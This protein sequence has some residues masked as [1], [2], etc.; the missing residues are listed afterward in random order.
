[1]RITSKGQVTIPIEIRESA[2]LLPGTDVA[3]RMQDGVVVVERTAST[4]TAPSR[5]DLAVRALYGKGMRGVTTDE[6]MTLL[7][8][9]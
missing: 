6:L 1:M 8:G 4:G 3:F 9:E 5:G 2:G 7:R